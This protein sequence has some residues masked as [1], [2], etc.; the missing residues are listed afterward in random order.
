MPAAVQY[1]FRVCLFL[2]VYTY[3]LYPVVLFLVYAIVQG[4][5]DLKYVLGRADRRV[6][7]TA[8]V[9]LPAISIIV[10]AFNE[11]R[12]LPRK[13]QNIHE[14]NY[15]KDRIQ[16]VIVSDG[17]TDGTN[18]ILGSLSDVNVEPVLLEARGG[19]ANA[20]NH[21]VKRARHDIFILTDASTAFDP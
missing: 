4:W 7:A 1:T 17:S 2:L 10:A 8:L 15:P 5:R 13:L 9:E 20:L 19:K 12:D 21:G 6:E 18:A 14:M 11:E 3:V 16:V